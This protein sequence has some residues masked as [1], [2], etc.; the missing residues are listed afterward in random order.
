MDRQGRIVI[1][2]AERDR[3]GVTDGATFEVLTTP[4]GVILERRRDATIERAEDGLPLV[5]LTD[6]ATITNDEA[7]AA[8]H[9]VRDG[10]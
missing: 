9:A 5:R 2:R 6:V 7:V 8:I 1:P 3:L 10:R 4:E